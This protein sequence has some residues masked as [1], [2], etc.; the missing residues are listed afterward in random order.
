MTQYDSGM[1]R[2]ATLPRQADIE[3]GRMMREYLD[4][5]IARLLLPQ[6]KVNSVQLERI[7]REAAV[8]LNFAKTTL[9]DIERMKQELTE[10]EQ[11]ALA[12]ILAED[13]DR[14]GP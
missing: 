13:K 12:R 2:F 1:Y 9:I 6:S 5:L 3:N 7:H 11:S 8:M 14:V 10:Q 4:R